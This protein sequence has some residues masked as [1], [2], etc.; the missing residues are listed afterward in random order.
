MTRKDDCSE[1]TLVRY[2]FA[3]IVILMSDIFFW[4]FHDSQDEGNE[5]VCDSS[6]SSPVIGNVPPCPRSRLALAKKLIVPDDVDVV[7]NST[8]T[9]HT[10]LICDA[11]SDDAY[12]FLQIASDLKF[13]RLSTL[14]RLQPKVN[15][16]VRKLHLGK[17][18][19]TYKM[20]NFISELMRSIHSYDWLTEH[21]MSTDMMKR[22][23]RERS[24]MDQ[25][26]LAELLGRFPFSFYSSLFHICNTLS[27]RINLTAILALTW[28]K[29]PAFRDLDDDY[30]IQ[31]CEKKARAQIG[32]FL[33]IVSR[34]A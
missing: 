4:Q 34:K 5:G 19:Q 33:T 6:V 11:L 10:Y 32:I 9:N 24:A 30:F 2:C 28:S 25:A 14:V 7:W 1:V 17:K 22:G 18:V 29:H 27:F 20:C 12:R 16:E 23:E 13:Y 21:K 31:V 26:E 15:A 3:L 8:V